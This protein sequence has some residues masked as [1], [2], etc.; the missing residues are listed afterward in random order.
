MPSLG[1]AA[2]FAHFRGASRWPGRMEGHIRIYLFEHGWFWWIPFA[3]DTTSIG[4]VLH[5]RV[6]KARQVSIERL[7]EEMVA[8]AP[9]VAAG[10]RGATRVSAVHR[11][12]NFAYKTTPAVGD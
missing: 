3:G 5:Q 7:F 2:L 8:A 4:C 10:L 1:K 12:A 6:V 11:V 9:S